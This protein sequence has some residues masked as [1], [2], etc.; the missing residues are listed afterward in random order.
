MLHCTNLHDSVHRIQREWNLQAIDTWLSVS[1]VE[2]C[3]MLEDA[4]TNCYDSSISYGIK[5]KIKM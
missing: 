4:V 5:I 1:I 2:L 3:V